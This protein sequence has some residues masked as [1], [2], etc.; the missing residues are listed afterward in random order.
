MKF[1]LPRPFLKFLH[2]FHFTIFAVVALGGLALVILSFFTTFS[3]SSTPS[4]S[5]GSTSSV[6][7]LDQ[8]TMKK[9]DSLQP[10]GTPSPLPNYPG[11]TDPF[12]E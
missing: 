11:R 12:S 2:R 3:R 10:S 9:V 1:H 8:A 5:G 7:V 4:V 6:P